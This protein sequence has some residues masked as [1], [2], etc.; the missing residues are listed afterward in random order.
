M[1]SLIPP[2]WS[3][4]TSARP[5]PFASRPWWNRDT[6]LRVL[7]DL[8][9]AELNRLRP[10][11]LGLRASA[12]SAVTTERRG[13]V[14]DAARR[15][16]AAFELDSLGLDSLEWLDITTLIAVQF[17]LHQTRLDNQLLQQRQLGAWAQIIL[18]SRARWDEALSFQT[19]GSTGQPKLCAHP[20]HRLEQEIHWF[21]GQL[22]DRRRVLTAV[23]AHHI[24]GF[25]FSAMLPALLGI[26][27]LDLRAGLPS[28]ALAQ[29]QPGDLI[30]GHPAFFE[31][32]TRGDG[33]VADDVIALTS[34]APCPPSLWQQLISAGCARVIEIYGSSEHAGIGVREA[35][36]V[37]FRLLPHWSRL[38]KT[39]D[40]LQPVEAPTGDQAHRV[41]QEA[42]TA[43]V[44]TSASDTDTASVTAAASALDTDAA[45][46]TH[47][48]SDSGSETVA[49]ANTDMAA[50]ATARRVLTEVELQDHLDWLDHE[51][52]F[53]L[54][55]RDGAVQIGGVNVFP[56]RI[57]RLLCTHPEVAEAAVR[58]ASAEQGGRLKAFVVPVADCIEPGQLAQR[59]DAWLASRV[60]ALERPRAI[61]IGRQ[62]PRS[63]AGKLIDWP[64][65]GPAE[66]G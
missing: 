66:S 2:Q 48:G 39:T 38:S 16:D 51:R 7:D 6:L 36:D 1:S 35:A 11:Q 9:W 65:E 19:S 55:R 59:L 62:L 22:S 34:T 13:S 61:Q 32:A 64:A 23:P 47:S 21:A 15:P 10:G 50:T 33:A 56:Q 3:P 17:H 12:Q 25:L 58:Q 20:I 4:A 8:L 24:Y 63:A 28:S 14:S 27:V 26:P 42:D 31:L 45:S 57:E 30:V 43:T 44:S 40:R 60:T 18:D 37:P 41:E 49:A 52:F 29:A 5:P 46:D 54:G 53:V